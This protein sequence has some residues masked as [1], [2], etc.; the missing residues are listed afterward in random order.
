MIEEWKDINILDGLYDGIF[1]VSNLGK[2]KSLDSILNEKDVREIKSRLAKGERVIDITKDFP[3]GK[4]TIQKIKS[5][6][7][8]KHI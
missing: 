3:V 2:V 8:W 1:Q 4:S 7:N 5:G 6:K